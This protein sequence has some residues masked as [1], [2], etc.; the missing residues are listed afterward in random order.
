M[1]GKPK[2]NTVDLETLTLDY[3]CRFILFPQHKRSVYVF[4][5]LHSLLPEA[6]T[7]VEL[8]CK[9]RCSYFEEHLPKITFAM[10][11]HHS[12]LLIRFT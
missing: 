8:L 10:H 12:L 11:T 6:A 3:R 5:G 4:I 9:K 2:M 1:L 7:R